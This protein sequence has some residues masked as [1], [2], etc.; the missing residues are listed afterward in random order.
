ML[1]NLSRNAGRRWGS[2]HIVIGL[3]GNLC[4]ALRCVGELL[5]YLLRFVSVFFRSRTSL[6]ARLLAAESQ[7]GMCKRRI[8]QKQQERY[9]LKLDG[10]LCPSVRRSQD[11][12][13]TGARAS[14]APGS[15]S[16]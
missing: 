6:A 8:E 9:V 4:N 12:A 10:P 5:G 2:F 7:L 11:A 13:R 15:L 14:L 3:F 1:P 16:A